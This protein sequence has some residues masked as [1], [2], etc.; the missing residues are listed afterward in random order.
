MREAASQQ[1]RAEE[2]ETGAH[3][4]SPKGGAGRGQGAAGDVSTD[5]PG[6]GVASRTVASRRAF[7]YPGCV[8]GAALLANGC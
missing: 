2:G 1:N 6:D 7:A 5:Y 3:L 8:P 4:S